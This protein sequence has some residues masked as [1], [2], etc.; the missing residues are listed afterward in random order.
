M[1]VCLC[2][3]QHEETMS[4]CGRRNIFA[5]ASEVTDGCVSERP[6]C[7]PTLSDTIRGVQRFQQYDGYIVLVM[8]Q[9]YR[10]ITLVHSYTYNMCADRVVFDD[11]DTINKRHVTHA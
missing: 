10:F 11:I 8:F 7:S 5:I 3:Q 6:A 4:A 1:C 9:L 2:V